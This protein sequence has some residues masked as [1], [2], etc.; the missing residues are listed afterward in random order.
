MKRT[1]L[2]GLFTLL[3]GAF[4]LLLLASIFYSCRSG[5]DPHNTRSSA[6]LHTPPVQEVQASPRTPQT[7]ELEASSR[8]SLDRARFP[9]HRL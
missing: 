8:R 5:E 9:D 7:A 3:T 2:T 6:S 4:A 1:A